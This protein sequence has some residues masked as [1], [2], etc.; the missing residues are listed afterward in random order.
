MDEAE[1][2]ER[3]IERSKQVPVVVDFWAPWCAPCRTLGPVLEQAIRELDGKIELVKVDTDESQLLAQRHRIQGIPAVKAFRNGQLVDEFTGNQPP[4]VVRQFVA[5]LVPSEKELAEKEALAE[6][7]AHL[8][9]GELDQV[10]P[11][12][13]RV[14][15][16][17]PRFDK[18]ESLRKMLELAKVAR[19]Y[20]GEEKARA[21]LAADEKDLEA[22]YALGTALAARGET[23]EALEQLLEIVTRSRKFR[24]D[25]GR[26]AMLTLFEHT[27]DD[28]LVREFRRRL[29]IVT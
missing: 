6:A 11:L 23:R 28:E 24:D 19:D 13:A 29:Q 14:D 16:R 10:E 2:H 18:V 7:A 5:Q 8:Q 20:G 17:G 22:R 9:A 27:S 3:V 26:R 15:L 1:F 4:P 25:A 12:L 21:R